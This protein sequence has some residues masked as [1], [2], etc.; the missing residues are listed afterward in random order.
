MSSIAHLT[1]GATLLALASA[2]PATSFDAETYHGSNC[3]RC[4]DTTVYTRE[5]RAMTSYDM[6]ESRVAGC[7]AR[8]G[9]KLPPD[10]LS[11]LVDHLNNNYYKFTK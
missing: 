9:E 11:G 10:G 6:L 7:D 1:A 2:S 5:N 3:T 4:H 8:F